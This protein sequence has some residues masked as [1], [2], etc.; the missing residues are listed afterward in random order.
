[1][2]TPGT[3]EKELTDIMDQI[4]RNTDVP[5]VVC[6]NGTERLRMAAVAEKTDG[7][8]MDA[9]FVQIMKEH[10]QAAPAV[11]AEFVKTTK[12]SL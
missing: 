12:N 4:R 5:C 11:V 7:V 6:L 9:P 10:A 2:A 8:V 1:M 3:H